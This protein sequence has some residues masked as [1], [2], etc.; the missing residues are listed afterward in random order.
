[1]ILNDC[2]TRFVHTT[3]K[4]LRVLSHKILVKIQHTFSQ[5]PSRILK[6]NGA[7]LDRLIFPPDEG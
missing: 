4:V 6:K 1:M 5:D 7:I 2:H 3:D